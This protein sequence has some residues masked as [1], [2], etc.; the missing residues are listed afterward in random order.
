MLGVR[1][2]SNGTGLHRLTVHDR[3][4]EFVGAFRGEHRTFAAVEERVVLKDPQRGL[5]RIDGR[6]VAVQHGFRGF[7]RVRH[8]RAVSLIALRRHG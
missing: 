8:A 5:N 6:A 1:Y 2:L 4:I 3:G 7:D